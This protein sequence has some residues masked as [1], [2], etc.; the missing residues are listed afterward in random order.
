[1]KHKKT[2]NFHPA[3][4]GLQHVMRT[5]PADKR[6]DAVREMKRTTGMSKVAMMEHIG[7]RV[8]HGFEAKPPTQEE[9]DA[10]HRLA[11]LKA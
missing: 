7:K 8:L 2:P 5:V 9:I 6:G 4:I 11:K 10:Q 1:M 3:M